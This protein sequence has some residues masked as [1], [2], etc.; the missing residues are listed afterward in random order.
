MAAGSVLI[1]DD[2]VDGLAW[3][4]ALL[5]L[6]G[7]ATLIAQDG[8][9]ALTLARRF[10]PDLILL[11]LR[12]PVMDGPAFRHAQAH[13]PEIAGIPVVC[14]SAEPD[15]ASVAQA[16]DAAAWLRKP[17]QIDRLLETLDAA[18]AHQ[19]DAWGDDLETAGLPD[20]PPPP[21][22]RGGDGDGSASGAR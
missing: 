17:V 2:D 11:D 1:V 22:S 3:V 13:D 21:E 4:R 20:G 12:M 10:R 8:A 18:G 9:D 19:W 16:L 14:M 6:E 15:V 5:E 7:Y